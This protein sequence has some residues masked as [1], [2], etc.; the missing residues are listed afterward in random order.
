MDKNINGYEKNPLIESVT[1]VILCGGEGKRLRPLTQSR[2]KPLLEIGGEAI[3]KK[4]LR[5]LSRDGIKK[6]I[7]TVGYLADMIEN[8]LGNEFEGISIEYIRENTPMGSAGGVKSAENKLSDIFLVLCGDAFFDF[9]LANAI[10]TLD[11]KKCDAVIVTSKSKNPLEFGVVCTNSDGRI[12]EFVEKPSWSAVC[13]D[14]INTGI[15]VFS[16]KVLSLI[17][18]DRPYDFGKDL[19]RKMLGLEMTVYAC[20]AD[21][22]WRDIG[23]P[24]SY[25]EC[26]MIASGNENIISPDCIIG[27]NSDIK[28]SIIGKNCVIGEDCRIKGAIIAD[29]C[30]IGS[31]VKLSPGCVIGKGSVLGDRALVGSGVILPC[32]YTLS[33]FSL[34]D[35]PLSSCDIFSVRSALFYSECR[36]K[37]RALG[38]AIT[39]AFPKLKIAACYERGSTRA[40]NSCLTFLRGCAKLSDNLWFLGGMGYAEARFAATQDD[41]DLTAF[42]RA[43]AIKTEIFFFDKNAAYPGAR[44]ESAVR[45]SAAFC[46]VSPSISEYPINV[47]QTNYRE[48]YIGKLK[49]ALPDK[50]AHS[51][52]I[53]GDDPGISACLE[54]NSNKIADKNDSTD[55]SAMSDS[56]KEKTDIKITIKNDGCEIEY[57]GVKFDE[58]HTKAVCLLYYLTKGI[59]DISLPYRSPFALHSLALGNK[60]NVRFYSLCPYCESDEIAIE[61]LKYTPALFDGNFAAAAFLSYITD[62][63]LSGRALASILPSFAIKQLELSVDESAKLPLIKKTENTAGEGEGNVIRRGKGRI[64]IIAENG[65][66]ITLLAESADEFSADELINDARKYISSVCKRS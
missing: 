22:M 43:G 21:G 44:F 23:D 40:K 9:S 57:D 30:R 53:K 10:E 35:N 61:K 6:A 18:D 34:V 25:F 32:N 55:D 46:G 13:S 31:G 56:E 63:E 19:F 39:R 45:Y 37:L 2:P 8:E 15:Y 48:L 50:L 3:I 29:D 5:R 38:L 66:N 4:I 11:R 59:S 33:A 52:D 27:K 51:V 47:P 28:R 20:H 24:S 49:D 14:E 17:P 36:D 58:D 64:R 62:M 42:V 54:C 16:K 65:P 41:Y 26:N 60:A 7:L 12:N 1:A